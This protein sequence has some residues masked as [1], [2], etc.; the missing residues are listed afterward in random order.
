MF[1]NPQAALPLPARPNVEQ[2]K[3]LAKELVK[4]CKSEP[5]AI[6]AWVSEWIRNLA[7]LS[8]LRA[9]PGAG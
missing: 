2:Y 7:R 8:G 5:Q 1:P 4:A 6:H 3:K 9:E